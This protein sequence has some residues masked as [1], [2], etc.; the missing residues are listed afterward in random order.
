MNASELAAKG[1]SSIAA[2]DSNITLQEEFKSLSSPKRNI[3]SYYPYESVI[4]MWP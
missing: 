2:I 3:A 4:N 1:A